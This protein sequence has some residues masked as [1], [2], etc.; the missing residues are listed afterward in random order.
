MVTIPPY[1]DPGT[2]THQ[3][4]PELWKF[5]KDYG[6]GVTMDAYS[7]PGL[8]FKEWIKAETR[9]QEQEKKAR[10]AKREAEK[11]RKKAKRR[12]KKERE[13]LLRL[14]LEG[15]ESGG[16]S[17]WQA[18]SESSKKIMSH[19]RKGRKTKGRRTWGES[20]AP[21]SEFQPPSVEELPAASTNAGLVFE[22]SFSEWELPFDI[23]GFGE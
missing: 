20:L 21:V 15:P 17:M 3:L 14:S 4:P 7:N 12:M 1:T 23:L 8:F 18:Y 13:S 6:A 16:E 19:K 11:A 2:P 9:R 22:L 5:D 10:K